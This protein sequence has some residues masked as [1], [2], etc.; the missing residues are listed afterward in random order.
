MEVYSVS[1]FQSWIVFLF[2]GNKGLLP[3]VPK[4]EKSSTRRS[5]NSTNP[6]VLNYK[7]T[8]LNIPNLLQSLESSKAAQHELE[9][10][11][12]N[13]QAMLGMTISLLS[14]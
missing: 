3:G 5:A 7:G 13:L 14:T 1:W 12:A 4:K 9:K 8:L 10:H 11:I 6:D 2:L